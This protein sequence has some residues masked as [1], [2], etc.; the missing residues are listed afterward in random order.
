M[1]RKNIYIYLIIFLILILAVFIAYQYI[2]SIYEVVIENEPEEL[3]ADNTSTMVIKA[4][5]INAL[6]RKAPFRKSSADFDIREGR[7]LIEIIQL[8]EGDG[9]LK[10][11]AKNIQGKVIIFVKAEYALLP[12]S[13]EITIYPNITEKFS[14]D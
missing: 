5:P 6:G 11:K 14:L 10:I 12:T 3:F 2:F 9:I 4:I 1:R 8:N 7:D 13:I